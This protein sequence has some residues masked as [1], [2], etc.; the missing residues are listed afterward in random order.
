MNKPGVQIEKRREFLHAVSGPGNRPLPQIGE[1]GMTFLLTILSAIIPSIFLLRFFY[2]RDVN[3]EPRGVLIKTF[4]LGVLTVI[5]VLIVVMP[6]IVFSPTFENPYVIGLFGALICAAIPEEFFKFLVVTR[7]SARNPAFDEPMDGIVYG[8][9]A[10][11]G[12]ATLENIL[13]V[14]DG[15]WGVAI[16]RA[17]TAVPCHACLGAILGYYVGQ[18]RFKNNGRLAWFGLMVAIALHALYDFPLMV[19]A[20]LNVDSDAFIGLGL[21]LFVFFVVVFTIEITWTLK[22]VKRL[23]RDQLVATQD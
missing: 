8:A 20:E 18:A 5:P 21:G 3:P 2:K 11:L 7:Y 13:Y 14:T 16:T 12:F 10:S 23:H 19:L 4:V 1:N 6:F 9:T 22:I 17:I 15:G